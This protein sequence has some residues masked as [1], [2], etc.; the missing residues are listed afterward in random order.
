GV[1]LHGPARCEPLVPIAPGVVVAVPVERYDWLT[2]GA[3][4]DLPGG[5]ALAVDGEREWMARA[6]EAWQVR[7]LA[8][9]VATVDVEQA[10]LAYARAQPQPS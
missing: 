2:D 9:G 4:F 8:A 5:L 10:L 6:G 7:V 1:V 3:T